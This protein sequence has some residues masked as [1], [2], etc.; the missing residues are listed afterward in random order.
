MEKQNSMLLTIVVHF[1]R[2][3]NKSEMNYQKWMKNAACK[4]IRPNKIILDFGKGSEI[5]QRSLM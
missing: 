3:L 5:M 4:L 1:D 2:S